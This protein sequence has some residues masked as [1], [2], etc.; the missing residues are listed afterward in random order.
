M[1]SASGW[2][3]RNCS[4]GSAGLAPRPGP[5]RPR[6][7]AVVDRRPAAQSQCQPDPAPAG[8]APYGSGRCAAGA[9]RGPGRGGGRGGRLGGGR[10]ADRTR[11]G[12]CRDRRHAPR[13]SAALP[14][15]YGM[16]V[17]DGQGVDAWST[18]PASTCDRCGRPSTPSPV[19]RITRTSRCAW[20]RPPPRSGTPLSGTA[21]GS[22]GGSRAEGPG[23]EGPAP[24]AARC[25]AEYI[26]PAAP[27]QTIR[28]RTPAPAAGWT[29]EPERGP[30]RPGHART[31]T[32]R[33]ARASA[34]VTTGGRRRRRS[35]PASVAPHT[36]TLLLC[37]GLRNALLCVCAMTAH[38]D[39]NPARKHRGRHKRPARRNR[40]GARRGRYWRY[41]SA[42]ALATALTA[43]A[44]W[45]RPGPRRPRRVTSTHFARQ[46]SAARRH[47]PR[48]PPRRAA[49][50]RLSHAPRRRCTTAPLRPRVPRPARDRRRSGARSRPP[51]GSRARRPLRPPA[52]AGD[53]AVPTA[54]SAVRTSVRVTVTTSL[55]RTCSRGPWARLMSPGPYCTVG[56]PSAAYNRRSLP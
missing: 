13:R 22:V 53:Q 52:A 32:A 7:P 18:A 10:V 9:G 42:A 11:R 36:R 3:F 30:A 31:M 24:R 29:G 51:P 27:P 25:R 16:S 43:F 19:L 12:P 15:G 6:V 40:H 49:P 28:S 26:T 55:R 8:L 45:S 46:T 4:S 56:M 39:R 35:S 20:N 41:A 1:A 34:A 33:W 48:R 5:A 17:P 50:L 14:H 23:R 37:G 54:R 2:T 47:R 21:S 38:C 44:P